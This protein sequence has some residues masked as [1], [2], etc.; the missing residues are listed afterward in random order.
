MDIVSRFVP[1]VFDAA[2]AEDILHRGGL[3]PTSECLAALEPLVTAYFDSEGP[4]R[5]AARQAITRALETPEAGQALARMLPQ[6]TAL[7][8]GASV[9]VAMRD[10]LAA[11]ELPPNLDGA[12]REG[13]RE[14][15]RGYFNEKSQ[16]EKDRLLKAVFMH[17][18]SARP[19][20]A[21]DI[22]AATEQKIAA[23]LRRH[24]PK[25]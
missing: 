4:A 18:N 14:T 7:R 15:I 17:A 10:V 8:A 1:S 20:A 16:P 5:E 22:D 9:A 24:Q 12:P 19:A 6:Y 23:S 21:G 2:I 13:L 11:A 3:A 25:F